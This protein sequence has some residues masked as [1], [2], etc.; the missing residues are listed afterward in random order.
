[1]LRK[2]QR[3]KSKRTWE[4]CRH[5]SDRCIW[6]PFSAVTQ[7]S[8]VIRVSFD[9]DYEVILKARLQRFGQHSEAGTM[10]PKCI[11]LENK[12]TFRV[13]G[14]ETLAQRTDRRSFVDAASTK[15][16]QML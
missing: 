8:S 16:A 3:A 12:A 13:V 14:L 10:A 9:E 11:R 6:Q 7:Q 4:S 15:L 2:E 5:V 1:M